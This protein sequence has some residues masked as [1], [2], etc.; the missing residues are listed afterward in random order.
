MA[1]TFGGL[2]RSPVARRTLGQAITPPVAPHV[3]PAPGGSYHV[4]PD[5]RKVFVR[6]SAAVPSYT[7]PYIHPMSAGEATT[8]PYIHPL[9]GQGGT[10]ANASAAAAQPA[11]PAAPAASGQ[12]ADPSGFTPDST[13]LLSQAAKTSALNNSL[14]A[15]D[16]QGQ[17][18]QATFTEAL[19]RLQAQQP[20]DEQSQREAANRQGLFYS[21]YLGS[22]LGKVATSYAQK[23]A[24]AQAS[25][26]N[27]EN[28]RLAARAAL[29]QGFTVDQAADMA[30]AVDRETTSDATAAGNDQLT[31]DP[32]TGAPTLSVGRPVSGGSGGTRAQAAKASRS[33]S[34]TPPY[35]HPLSA[36]YGVP[37]YIHPL[38]GRRR[39]T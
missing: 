19:R 10:G 33:V 38:G 11:A 3:Q 6:H 1:G 39:R 16:A 2:T 8:P 27:Q 32:T 24:D 28:A 4:Y 9:S 25:F 7:P 22:Q 29:Q 37:S 26:Q 17:T 13:Y 20:L 18:N 23:R 21:G 15:N 34:Y 36:G 14:A 30:A 35:V 31:T 12:A 5:G